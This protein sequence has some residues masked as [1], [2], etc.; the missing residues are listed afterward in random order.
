M[1]EQKVC[2]ERH[3]RK[4]T[5]RDDGQRNSKYRPVADDEVTRTRR[6]LRPTRTRIIFR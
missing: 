4:I 3:I 6:Y 1:E 2:P 5:S